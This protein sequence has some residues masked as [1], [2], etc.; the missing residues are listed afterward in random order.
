MY[1]R[2]CHKKLYSIPK[3]ALVMILLIAMSVPTSAAFAA[4]N[5]TGG[6]ILDDYEG[7][8]SF[9]DYGTQGGAFFVDAFPKKMTVR[10]GDEIHLSSNVTFPSG[11]KE[12][13]YD[14][15]IEISDES[16]LTE[17]DSIGGFAFRAVKQG[18]AVLKVVEIELVHSN[19]GYE[20]VEIGTPNYVEIT[21]IDRKSLV[22]D[23]A[24]VL[25]QVKSGIGRRTPYVYCDRVDVGF[26]PTNLSGHL[27]DTIFELW[28]SKEKNGTYKKV[29]SATINEL[30][31][32][33]TDYWETSIGG[34][35]SNGKYYFTDRKKVKAD[36]AYYYKIRS[37]FSYA[38]V[39]SEFSEP[40]K[41]WTAPKPIWKVSYSKSSKR[42]SWKK[43]KKAAGYVYW[44]EVDGA[45]KWNSSYT[46]I[47]RDSF[48]LGYR[49]TKT[50]SKRGAK[51]AY[52][53]PYK[54]HGDY[55]YMDWQPMTK[56][57]STLE[58]PEYQGDKVSKS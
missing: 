20:H 11:Q 57:K 8:W 12:Y 6:L 58:D 43:Q 22:S 9:S 39:Y 47:Y 4:D 14:C 40:Q 32:A 51:A 26:K 46:D 41:Y 1:K 54:K 55:Y 42:S 15:E 34:E 17:A 18:V 25:P 56:Y 3:I 13:L 10:T 48:Y 21:V 5:T 38:N 24:N 49:T 52:V 36:T 29:A 35:L 27:D 37:R 2:K 50:Y 33:E 7:Y 19:L 45:W 53:T 16:V 44:I 23:N 31:D 30:R 28:R